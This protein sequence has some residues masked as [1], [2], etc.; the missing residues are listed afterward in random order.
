MIRRGEWSARISSATDIGVR[1]LN[2]PTSAL[3]AVASGFMTRL[4]QVVR[5]AGRPATEAAIVGLRFA[6]KVCLRRR[7]RAAKIPEQSRNVSGGLDK[8]RGSAGTLTP[9]GWLRLVLFQEGSTRAGDQRGA[10]ADDGPNG[11]AGNTRS[12]NNDSASSTPRPRMVMS[13]SMATSRVASS[14]GRSPAARGRDRSRAGPRR[15]GPGDGGPGPAG[16]R[17]GPTRPAAP[18]PAPGRRRPTPSRRGGSRPP[19]AASGRP[20]RRRP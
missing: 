10:P 11:P 14:A 17:R 15:A 4:P 18:R 5:P 7:L 12:S 1:R 8:S 16:S 19:R 13:A 2:L 3:W 6:S 20:A 9:P